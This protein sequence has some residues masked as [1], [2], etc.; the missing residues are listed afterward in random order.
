MTMSSQ[1]SCCCEK[2]PTPK[3]FCARIDEGRFP[4]QPVLPPGVKIVPHLDRSDLVHLTTHT[5]LHNL[6]EGIFLVVIILFLFLGNLRGALI[7]ALTIPFSLLFASIC[8]DLRHIPANLLSLGAL[9]FG[10]IVEGAVVMVENIVRYFRTQPEPEQHERGREHPRGRARS[11]AAGLLR[12]H[13][14]HHRVPADLHSA[15]GG[16]PVVQAHGVDGGVRAAGRLFFSMFLAPV[17]ASLVSEGHQGMATTRR[18]LDHG[19]LQQTLDWMHRALAKVALAIALFAFGHTAYLS[20]RLSARNFCRIWMKAP[21]GRAARWPPAP[22]RREGMRIMNQA[23][24]DLREFPE[25]TQVVSQV[26]RPDDGTDTT[27]FFNT[28]YFVDLKPHEQ[29]RPQFHRIKTR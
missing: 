20:W 23:R 26:G 17:L 12:D 25:V 18:D 4:Q 22:D 13:H 21:S 5:V 29:W 3:R 2:A 19:S 15:A 1:A 9:D 27:G 11:A 28:E 7:V 14:H 16:R 10:M 6:S 24:L 8:L